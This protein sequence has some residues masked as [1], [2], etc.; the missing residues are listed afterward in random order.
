MID[1]ECKGLELKPLKY[2]ADRV[3][4]LR[5]APT[6]QQYRFVDAYLKTEN[7]GKAYT[8]AGYMPKMNAKAKSYVR[9]LGNNVRKEI[10]VSFI[11][12]MM[13]RDWFIERQMTV[14]Y[15]LNEAMKTYDNADNA[16]D[17]L[18]ALRFVAELGGYRGKAGTGS[19]RIPPPPR[20]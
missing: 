10:G 16:K 5:F 17:K 19:K 4:E 20:K 9:L 2:Y 12:D 18:N 1:K 11:F 13:L 3:G 15:L 6:Q 8:M 14:E 7:M